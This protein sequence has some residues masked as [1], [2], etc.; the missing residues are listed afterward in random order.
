ME[1]RAID[2]LRDILLTAKFPEPSWDEVYDMVKHDPVRV[3]LWEKH[4]SMIESK[5][6][7]LVGTSWEF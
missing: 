6:L 5:N 3:K 1:F 2:T 7:H 4:H